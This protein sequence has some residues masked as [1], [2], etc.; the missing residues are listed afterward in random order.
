ML[1][2]FSA[3]LSAPSS[4]TLQPERL[5]ASVQSPAALVDYWT[6][7][8]RDHETSP[9]K[10]K[11]PKDKASLVSTEIEY[12]PS[13]YRGTACESWCSDEVKVDRATAE[14]AGRKHFP[15][16]DVAGMPRQASRP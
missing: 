14:A 7:R 13:L 15:P 10:P 11:I 5:H 1:S 6:A 4:G 16:N 3:A 12:N 2:F 9:H 8:V